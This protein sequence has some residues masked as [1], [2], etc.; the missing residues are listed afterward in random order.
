MLSLVLLLQTPGAYFPNS[1]VIYHF[2][3]CMGLFGGGICK[4]VAA[5]LQL[6]VISTQS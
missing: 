1:S 4:V 3:K 6:A 5:S 2:L